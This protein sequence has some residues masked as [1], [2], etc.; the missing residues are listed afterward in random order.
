MPN[1]RL[2]LHLAGQRIGN[3][4]LINRINAGGMAEVYLASPSVDESGTAQDAIASPG[5]MVAIKV[6]SP[7][8]EI[9]L[10]SGISDIEQHFIG[11]G[12]LLKALHHP[13]ILPV[14]ESGADRGYLYHVMEYVPAGSLADAISG[15]STQA[16]HLPL[17]LPEAVEIIR[18]VGSALQY[19]HERDIVH[20]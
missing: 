18:Q 12:A 8:N 17:R 15:R 4:R 2:R 5:R 7:T 6:V 9:T 19:I 16:L 14:Y 10:E 11:E 3:Y 13:Y 20:R 1:E